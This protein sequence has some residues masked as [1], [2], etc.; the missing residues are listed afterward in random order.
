[1]AGMPAFWAARP[2]GGAEVVV[3]GDDEE[4]GAVLHLFG[5]G[6]GRLLALG[7][8]VADGEL[9]LPAEQAAGGVDLVD[10]QLGGAEARLVVGAHPAAL[11]DGEADL[12]RLV[13]EGRPGGDERREDQGQALRG[14]GHGHAPGSLRAAACTGEAAVA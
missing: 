13:G 5:A 3:G 4:V 11:G 7:L 14:K 6:L 1:M 12:D 9:D 2:A 8:G 10:L